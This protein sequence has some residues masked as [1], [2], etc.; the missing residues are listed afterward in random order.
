MKSQTQKNKHTRFISYAE[1][2][3]VFACVHD[4]CVLC[5]CV[6]IVCVQ[7]NCLHLCACACAPEGL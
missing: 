5:V 6:C 4:M 2:V 3:C 1:S 7:V